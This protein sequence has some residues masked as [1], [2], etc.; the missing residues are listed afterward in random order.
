[1]CET[2][3]EREW[4]EVKRFRKVAAE[5][6]ALKRLLAERDLQIDAMKKAAARKG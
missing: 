4:A 6:K 2:L 3:G 1:V 5:N